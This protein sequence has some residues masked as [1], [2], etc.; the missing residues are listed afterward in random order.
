MV[1]FAHLDYS[2]CTSQCSFML[3]GKQKQTQ[4][5]LL[6]IKFQGYFF[7]YSN[8]Q[9]IKNIIFNLLRIKVLFTHLTCVE[10]QSK[11]R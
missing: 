5:A 2:H 1:K 11:G 3:L 7:E 10:E 4:L 8:N 9:S 6:V